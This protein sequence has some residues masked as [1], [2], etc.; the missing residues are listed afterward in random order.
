MVEE[1]KTH[2]PGPYRLGSIIIT[3][4]DLAKHATNYLVES[5]LVGITADVPWMT[6]NTQAERDM[7]MD[8]DVLNGDPVATP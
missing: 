5:V 2:P 6:A 4:L 8:N 7:T 1:R 3:G